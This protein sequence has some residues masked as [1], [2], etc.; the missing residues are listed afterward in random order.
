M[1]RR[2]SDRLQPSLRD[3]NGLLDTRD[4]ALETPGYSR[5]VPLGL[6]PYPK[7]CGAGS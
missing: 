3:L 5:S 7:E 6:K 1:N 2:K 4:P